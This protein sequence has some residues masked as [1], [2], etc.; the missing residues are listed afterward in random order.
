MRS[1]KQF[2]ESATRSRNYGSDN[3][4]GNRRRVLG[5]LGRG[6]DVKERVVGALG[7]AGVLGIKH[8]IYPTM[9]HYGCILSTVTLR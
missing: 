5:I 1:S 9:F 7:G 6:E 2:A 4:R 8:V 3:S